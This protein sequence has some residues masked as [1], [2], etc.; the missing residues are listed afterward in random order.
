MNPILDDDSDDEDDASD[1]E[2]SGNED[3]DDSVEDDEF[4]GDI[5]IDVDDN[6]D[7]NTGKNN[8]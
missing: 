1:P 2:N 7:D 6:G 4:S 5:I 8:S 3:S